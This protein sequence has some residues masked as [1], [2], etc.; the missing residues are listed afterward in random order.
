MFFL[1]NETISVLIEK[2][3]AQLRSLKSKRSATEFLWPGDEKYWNKSSPLLFP[4]VGGLKDDEYSYNGRYFMLGRHGFARDSDFDIVNISHESIKLTLRYSDKTVDIY[5][6]KFEIDVIFSLKNLALEVCYVVKNLDDKSIL[7]SVG[8]HPAINLKAFNYSELDGFYLK[9]MSDIYLTKY[10][11]N[12]N[13]VSLNPETVNLDGGELALSNN[14]FKD[15]VWILKGLKSNEIILK[16]QRQY[17]IVRLDRGSF[18]YLGLWAPIGAPFICIEPWQGIADFEN[19][20]KELARKEGM[21]KLSV[22]K[23][24]VGSWSIAFEE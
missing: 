15:D 12:N 9:F 17:P 14:M 13:L 5:P 22:G 21:V 3:G 20:D 4:I 23:Q 6:F 1:E 7:F 16:A 2:K 18:P 11:L 19:H 10:R 24:W 8:G